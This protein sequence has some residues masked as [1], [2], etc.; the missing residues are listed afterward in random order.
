MST[1]GP[2][3]RLVAGMRIP[4]AKP[5]ALA[6]A[7]GWPLFASYELGTRATPDGENRAGWQIHVRCGWPQCQQSVLCSSNDSGSYLWSWRDQLGPGVLAHIY[8]CHRQL[9]GVD[10]LPGARGTQ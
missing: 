8:Q 3:P 10:A 5:E 4:A 6:I 2:G 7:R 1:D 9:S